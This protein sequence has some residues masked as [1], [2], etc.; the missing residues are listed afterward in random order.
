MATLI[1]YSGAIVAGAGAAGRC[2]PGTTTITPD[3]CGITDAFGRVVTSGWG[4]ADCLGVWVVSNAGTDTYQVSG[5]RGISDTIAG[6]SG[7]DINLTGVTGSVLDGTIQIWIPASTNPAGSDVLYI[8]LGYN[9]TPSSASDYIYISLPLTDGTTG[10]LGAARYGTGSAY[11]TPPYAFGGSGLYTLHFRFD[12]TGTYASIWPL[13]GSDPGTWQAYSTV[14]SPIVTTAMFDLQFSL[15]TGYIIAFANLNIPGVNSCYPI[16]PVT[17]IDTFNRVVPSGFGTASDGSVWTA[18]NWGSSSSL[19]SVNGSQGVMQYES[20]DFAVSLPITVTMPYTLTFTFTPTFGTPYYGPEY[21]FGV[22]DPVTWS[23]D[24]RSVNTDLVY[25]SY[26]GAGGPWQLLV[27]TATG[28]T[29]FTGGSLTSGLP[30]VLALDY[31]STTMTATLTQAGSTIITGSR[32]RSGS[33]ATNLFALFYPSLSDS[34]G[35]DLLSIDN[36]A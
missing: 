7:S 20:D 28:S 30:Y 15:V 17:A 3:L 9:A 35:A 27:S 14:A 12:G 13:A 22:W 21:H 34:A 25:L 10:S 19:T 32:S 23:G 31:T 16:P 36:I 33:V 5:G 26:S 8:N 2:G 4:T 24:P 11:T 6:A 29:T 18:Y 1:G